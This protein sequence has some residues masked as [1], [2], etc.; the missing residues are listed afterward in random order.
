MVTVGTRVIDKSHFLVGGCGGC[1]GKQINLY[2][3]TLDIRH[4]ELPNLS[5]S[6]T[7]IRTHLQIHIIPQT[8]VLFPAN[9]VQVIGRHMM[10]GEITL[11]NFHFMQVYISVKRGIIKSDQ[12]VSIKL[13]CL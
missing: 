7:H 13:L 9:Q 5:L 2:V 8:L 4:K 6:Y 3:G 12:K 11:V 10:L 1:G